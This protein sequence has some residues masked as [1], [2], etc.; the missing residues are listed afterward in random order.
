MGSIHGELGLPMEVG[1]ICLAQRK[2]AADLQ[3]RE[4]KLGERT[5]VTPHDT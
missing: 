1:R 4:T 5:V 2:I 3:L